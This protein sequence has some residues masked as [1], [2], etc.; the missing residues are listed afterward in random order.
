MKVQHD[1]AQ[2]FRDTD[3]RETESL[4]AYYTDRIKALTKRIAELEA[5]VKRLQKQDL[6]NLSM[7]LDSLLDCFWFRGKHE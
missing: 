5:E 2:E 3:N 7:Q 4:L 6:E 1:L